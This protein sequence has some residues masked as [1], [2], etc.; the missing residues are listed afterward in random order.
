MEKLLVTRKMAADLLSVSLK[1]IDRLRE[2]NKLRALNIGSHVYFTPDELR[3]FCSK[4][5]DKC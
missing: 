3:A 2:E 5:V 1:T 4:E